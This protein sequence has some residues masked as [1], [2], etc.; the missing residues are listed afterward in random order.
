M[1]LVLY[2]LSAVYILLG[3]G[4]VA[5]Y[6]RSKNVGLLM[7]AV[8]VGCSVAI[9]LPFMTPWPFLVGGVLGVTLWILV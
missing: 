7:V 3:L 1:D 9:A 5:G 2:V 8:I 6:W 4:L